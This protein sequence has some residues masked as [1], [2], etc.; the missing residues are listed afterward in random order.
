MGE[1]FLITLRE[2]LEA[3]LI[4]AIVLAYLNRTGNRHQFKYAWLGVGLAAMV[5]FLFVGVYLAIGSI[6]QGTANKLYE[7]L[8]TIFAAGLLT[9]MIF[10]MRKASRGLKKEIEGKVDVALSLNSP[11][12]VSAVTFLAVIREAAEEVVMVSPGIAR[13]ANAFWP[14]LGVL[15]GF[16]IAIFIGYTF[17]KGAA[18]VNLRTF[19]NITGVVLIVL[20]AGLIA[21]G[22]HE[23]AEIGLP[24]IPEGAKAWD[25]S[26]ALPLLSTEHP[27]GSILKGLIG[28]RPSPNWPEVIVYSTYLLFTLAAFLKPVTVERL[29]DRN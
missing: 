12:A 21:Y 28:F 13:G 14:S 6:L 16:A 8:T 15:L 25:M 29:A 24:F 11:L 2:G 23:L 9:W 26:K 3:A 10:W 22:Y 18:L 20:A 27:V 19:F 7:G 1:T 5:S 17:Y 4:V